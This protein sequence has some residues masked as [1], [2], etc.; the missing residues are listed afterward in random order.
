[1]KIAL[2]SIGFFR[3]G[4]GGASSAARI[5]PNRILFELITE[6]AVY[7]PGG[8]I[9]QGVGAVFVH[10]TGQVTVSRT[11]G[12]GHYA[13]MTARFLSNQARPKVDWPRCFLWEDPREALRFAE[14]MLRA[15]HRTGQDRGVIGDLVWSQFRYHLDQYQRRVH[16][17]GIPPRLASVLVYIEQHYSEPLSIDSL[18]E[19]VGLSSS[20]LHAEFRHYLGIS[21]HQ[22]LIQQRMRVAQHRLATTSDPIKA[23]AATV[24][25]ANMENFC[26]AFKNHSNLTAA[27]YRQKYRTYER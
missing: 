8:N 13:C 23:V 12:K 15:F 17:Q 25:Y 10:R 9:L 26:R 5:E 18:A 22:H 21:P 24:G 14:D 4:P 7:M 16:A 6:G 20:H 3:S 2:E 1:M 11:E 19:Q 27:A